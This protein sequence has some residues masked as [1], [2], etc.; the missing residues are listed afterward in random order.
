MALS[1]NPIQY[2]KKKEK[3][4]QMIIIIHLTSQMASTAATQLCYWSAKPETICKK[5]WA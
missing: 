1:S 3:K 4:G 2:H 5:K